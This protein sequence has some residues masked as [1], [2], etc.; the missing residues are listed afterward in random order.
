[1]LAPELRLLA[2]SALLGLVHIVLASHAASLQRGYKW[3]AGARDEPLAPLTGT[4]GRLARALSNFGETFPIF[5]ALV[6]AVLVAGRSSPLSQWG[7]LLYFWARVAY[8]PLYAFGVPL[9][10]SLAWNV[11]AVGIGLLGAALLVG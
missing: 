2:Y 11:S 6:L 3:T 7:A 9:V 4:A 1:V 8:L 10:R 5:A